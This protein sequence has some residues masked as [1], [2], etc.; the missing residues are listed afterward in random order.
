MI[1]IRKILLVSGLA[2][3]IT[4]SC[5]KDFPDLT[6]NAL[7][8]AGNSGLLQAGPSFQLGGTVTGLTD[9]GLTLSAAGQTVT[10]NA[11]GSFA[12]P[13]A[14]AEGT[15]YA[16]TVSAAPAGY[17]CNVY[18]GTGTLGADTFNVEVD[19]IKAATITPQS[20]TVLGV[21]EDIII[22]F[23]NSMN[24]AGCTVLTGADPENLGASTTITPAWSATSRTN[25]TLTLT[26]S[27]QWSPSTGERYLWLQNCTTASGTV[28]PLV[29]VRYNLTGKTWYVSTTGTD[30]ADCKIRTA[31]CR[32]IQHAIDQANGDAY[33]CA[34]NQNCLVLLTAGTFSPPDSIDMRNGISVIG[35]YANDFLSRG[36][37]ATV[38]KGDG[39]PC[40]VAPGANPRCMVS[41]LAGTTSRTCL[42]S[43]TI[44]GPDNAHTL[45]TVPDTVY[46]VEFA[47]TGGTLKNADLYSGGN[48]TIY[49]RVGVYADGANTAD[50]AILIS[51]TDFF[52]HNPASSVVISR[53]IEAVGGK[54][55]MLRNRINGGPTNAGT[56]STGIMV[57]PPASIEAYLNRIYGGT[58]T[59]S[60][61]VISTSTEAD[62]FLYYN[63]LEAGNSASTGL[64][65]QVP[66]LKVFNNTINGNG[67]AYCIA[68]ADGSF[69]KNNAVYNCT[70]GI[71]PT[72]VDVLNNVF[73][74]PLLDAS[75]LYTA[76]S[77]CSVVL[78]GIDHDPVLTAFPSAT[79]P[80]IESEVRWDDAFDI[81]YQARDSDSI[82]SIGLDETTICLP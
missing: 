4:A 78:G 46:A 69:I 61:P 8:F 68:G 52:W 20:G 63:Y 3:A 23:S 40:I 71:E 12:F 55:F 42:S 13:Q 36:A 47:N 64:R 25:D 62:S 15:N 79:T 59:S 39:G 81:Q 18:N 16:V 7:L 1:H 54:T 5:I 73:A 49:K 37:A 58:A 28:L 14:I 74:D 33:N 51:G 72:G 2:V 21:S 22:V 11:S 38:I 57:T 70:S 43:V 66:G 34:I 19:C 65:L 35:T 6:N 29:R 17:Q 80:D 44:D 26:P 67:S 45:G 31:P 60:Y 53:A 10:M 9:P 75:Q 30:S 56:T 41:F 27:P 82:F 48:S 24:T 77:P 32:S 76:N 50:G